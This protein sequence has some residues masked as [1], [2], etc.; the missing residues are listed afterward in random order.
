MALQ[1]L[2]HGD[3]KLDSLRLLGQPVDTPIIDDHLAFLARC[4]KGALH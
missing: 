4:L 3:V 1:E 2:G